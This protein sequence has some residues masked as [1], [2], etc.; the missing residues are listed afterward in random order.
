MIVGAMPRFLVGC[1]V[2][3]VG[4]VDLDQCGF[5]AWAPVC[6]RSGFPPQQVAR[7]RMSVL[8]TSERSELWRRF[9]RATSTLVCILVLLFPFAGGASTSFAAASEVPRHELAAHQQLPDRSICCEDGEQ[10]CPSEHQDHDQHDG[11]P[12]GGLGCVSLSVLPDAAGW[13][14][15][16]RPVW[17]PAID[18]VCLSGQAY[19]RFQPPRT[20]ART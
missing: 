10:H 5:V 4:P 16:G 19:S 15:F 3:Q 13:E 6:V 1:R 18:A 2:R 11:T 17:E 9:K 12:C 7:R 8:E 14:P 20:C